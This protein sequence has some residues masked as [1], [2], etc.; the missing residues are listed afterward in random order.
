MRSSGDKRHLYIREIKFTFT[1]DLLLTLYCFFLENLR[2]QQGDHILN[3]TLIYIGIY[4]CW[5]KSWYSIDRI[6]GHCH[7][8]LFFFISMKIMLN[9]TSIKNMLPVQRI[10]FSRHVEGYRTSTI[11]CIDR[12]CSLLN[13]EW[14]KS[15]TKEKYI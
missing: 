11:T 14:Q 9:Q 4:K 6:Q 13:F 5:V 12:S 8:I 3:I 1:F 10:Q 7:F 2:F 15:F